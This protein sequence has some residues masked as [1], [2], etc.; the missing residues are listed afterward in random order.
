MPVNLTSEVVP[1]SL[2]TGYYGFENADKSILKSLYVTIYNEHRTAM[3]V[4]LKLFSVMADKDADQSEVIT[5]K[6]GEYNAGGYVRVRLQPE[7]QRALA[8]SLKIDIAEKVIVSSVVAEIVEG[9]TATV[10][11]SRSK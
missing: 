3:S 4:G 2:Q 8:S 10:A 1:L 11:P 7:Q 5:V 9:E 6:P